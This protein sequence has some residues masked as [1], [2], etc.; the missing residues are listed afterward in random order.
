MREPMVIDLPLE[1]PDYFEILSKA[2][3]V[4][5]RSGLVTLQPGEDCGLHSTEDYEEM[6]VILEGQGEIETEG[7]GRRRIAKGQVAYN[8]PE[9][10]HNVHNTGTEQLRYIYV[11]SKAV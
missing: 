6:I 4:R 11:V 9:T 1:K 8:P 5:M 2:N 3:A 7:I 10:E